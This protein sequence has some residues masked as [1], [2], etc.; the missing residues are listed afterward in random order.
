M[1]KLKLVSCLLSVV[2]FCGTLT[3]C[4]GLVNKTTINEDGSGSFVSFVGYTKAGLDA[5]SSLSEDSSAI[6]IS[7]LTPFIHNGITYYGVQ[8]TEYFNSC[9]EF[10]KTFRE[11]INNEEN[12]S[13]LV[14]RE[15]GSFV[16]KF[17]GEITSTSEDAIMEQA[18]S[19]INLTADSQAMLEEM[20][21]EMVL[22]FAFSF[23]YP[24]TQSGGEM[25]DGV[26][27]DGNVLTIDLIKISTA[28]TEMAKTEASLEFVASKSQPGE[29]Q[30]LFNDVPYG[31]WYFDAIEFL[32]AQGLVAGNGDGTFNPDG[33]LT[34]AEFCQIIARANKAET[35][36]LNGYWAGKAIQHCKNWNFIKDLGPII[37]ANYDVPISREVAVSGVYRMTR[38]FLPEKNSSIT[39]YSIPDY[40]SI[41]EDYRN[42][43]LLAYQS[44]L[45][46]GSDSN[47]T[48]NPKSTLTRAEFCQLFYNAGFKFKN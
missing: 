29:P 27:I 28:F 3:G 4:I 24:V 2:M 34:Y 33:A 6:D 1:K 26:V 11:A 38:S 30:Y 41:D 22:V 21:K 10:N 37:A 40:F 47:G 35:G 15:D 45:S 44:G 8:T 9:E 12:A 48:F 23:P 13:S 32:T 19:S 46:H 42:D 14:K 31:A 36:V 43:I 18:S 25:V 7:S 17:C 39:E 5:L 16:L 20:S